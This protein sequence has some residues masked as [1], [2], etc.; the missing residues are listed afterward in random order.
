MKLPDG[1]EIRITSAEQLA[2]VLTSN[3]QATK[4]WLQ[5]FIELFTTVDQKTIKTDILRGKQRDKGELYAPFVVA[6]MSRGMTEA[7]AKQRH[8][9]AN[10]LF[11]G[12]LHGKATDISNASGYWPAVDIARKQKQADAEVK[13]AVA[14]RTAVA[15]IRAEL[16][17]AA[18]E[19][20]DLN[21]IRDEAVEKLDEQTAQKAA[22]AALERTETAAN[23]LGFTLF[24]MQPAVEDVVRV[25]LKSGMDR[26]EV[27]LRLDEAYKR[28]ADAIKR[29][30]MEA[31]SIAEGAKAVA[32][33]ERNQ[34]RAT[35]IPPVPEVVKA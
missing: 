12:W 19:D 2:V 3:Q 1:K 26:D 25:C 6:L 15:V 23:K 24:P 33:A 21:A 9:E 30:D 4:T 29:Q 11:Y 17:D 27:V 22:Q 13:A 10:S 35:A 34:H 5:G 20:A 7:T 14:R 28:F 32:A 18:G 31:A 16:E 8:S